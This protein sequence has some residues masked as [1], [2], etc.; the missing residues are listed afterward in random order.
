MRKGERYDGLVMSALSRHTYKHARDHG[1]GLF[2]GWRGGAEAKTGREPSPRRRNA[3]GR[4]LGPSRQ[5]LAIVWIGGMVW[6]DIVC[7]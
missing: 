2:R 4:E 1:P 7:N 6:Y 3:T 5:T